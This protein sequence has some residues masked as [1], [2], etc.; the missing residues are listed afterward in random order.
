MEIQGNTDNS[1][2]A[3]YNQI[4]SENRAK[5]VMDYFIKA[6]IGSDRLTAKGYGLTKPAF[7]N[8]S[9]ENMAKNRRVELKPLR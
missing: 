1:G 2:S 8:T 4:L 9:S 7:P 5:L 6:G 3:E